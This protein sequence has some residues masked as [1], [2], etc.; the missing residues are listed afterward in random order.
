MIYGDKVY[1][2]GEIRI[3]DTNAIMQSGNLYPYCMNNPVMYSDP[4]GESGTGA[5]II[6]V[7]SAAVISGIY[8]G[9]ANAI[10][11][12]SFWGGFANG[13]TA[14][15]STAIG[16][17]ISP[18]VGTVIGSVF[19]SALGS[20]IENV[21]Q[22]PNA[23]ITVYVNDAAKSAAIGILSGL[24][25]AYWDE[26]IKIADEASSAAQSLMKYDPKFG[27]VIKEFFGA[28]GTFLEE[29]VE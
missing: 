4:S 15:L 23:D 8:S 24:G 22:N 11:G 1:Q 5:V 29:E 21:I 7:A 20:V 9:A 10:N 27:R 17:V 3:P 25:S 26:A 14:G 19:G 12:E 2:K 16:S 28:V 13:F 6:G 18:G